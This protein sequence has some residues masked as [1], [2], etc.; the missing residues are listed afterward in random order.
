MNA[1]TPLG[2]RGRSVISLVSRHRSSLD[3][4]TEQALLEFDADFDAAVVERLCRAVNAIS[5]VHAALVAWDDDLLF[6]SLDSVVVDD[7]EED[8]AS[9]PVEDNDQ[10]YGQILREEIAEFAALHCRVM[11]QVKDFLVKPVLPLVREYFQRLQTSVPT[12]LVTPDFSP[13]IIE[14]C[15][16]N[17]A[18]LVAINKYMCKDGASS[19]WNEYATALDTMMY[20]QITMTTGFTSSIVTQFRFDIKQ[21]LLAFFA[22][23]TAGKSGAA[24]G[25]VFRWVSESCALLSLDE[26]NWS[27]LSG[28]LGMSS[29]NSDQTSELQKLGMVSP[30]S[31]VVE[32]TQLLPM[33]KLLLRSHYHA[34]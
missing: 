34:H 31:M 33:E 8:D 29:C 12:D 9:D 11:A 27:R 20:N 32:Y 25:N 2:A 13:K 30:P 28:L 4:E 3:V 6:V 26:G 10:P 24:T 19:F 15:Q 5:S 18:Y 21:G 7:S 14:I 22:A 1:A 17:K 23:V 16:H